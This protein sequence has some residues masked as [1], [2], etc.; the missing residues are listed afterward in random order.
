MLQKLGFGRT[1]TVWLC[2]E[3]ATGKWFAIKVH[4]AKTSDKDS[5]EVMATRVLLGPGGQDHAGATHVVTPLE[6]F[7]TNSPNG[8]HLCLVMPVLGPNLMDWRRHHV[9]RNDD[10]ARRLCRQVAEGMDYMHSKGLCH[11]DFRPGS[12]FMKLRPGCLDGMTRADMWKEFREAPYAE[13]VGMDGRK[14][15]HAPEWVV[16]PI[17]AW[18]FAQYATDDIA[19]INFGEAY[20]PSTLEPPKALKIPATLHIPLAYAAPEAAFE[21]PER[22]FGK[23]TD[24]WAL[25]CTLLE[26]RRGE[27]LGGGVEDVV[28]NM[29][30]L[31]GEAV[32]FPYRPAAER[33]LAEAKA[34]RDGDE[35]L[36]LKPLVTPL[37]QILG[38]V[39]NKE[40]SKA[41]FT[42]PI[43]TLIG[44]Y[45][46]NSEGKIAGTRLKP[47]NHNLPDKE[48]IAFVNLLRLVFKYNEKERISTHEVVEHPWITGK[49]AEEVPTTKEEDDNLSGIPVFVWI[50]IVLLAME[51]SL[52]PFVNPDLLAVFAGS[53]HHQPAPAVPCSSIFF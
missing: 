38:H 52:I 48:F 47:L 11:G 30:W 53:T 22:R 42:D 39:R 20:A 44:R 46:M 3:T 29:E 6:T 32:P 2:L 36:S 34:Q 14:S 7:H 13:V 26:V 45:M 51:L 31:I 18:R 9:L 21:A 35:G 19:I 8:R 49:Y 25:A 28:R 27:W 15:Q 16:A 33:M 43:E 50:L 41:T 5:R 24:V 23:G 1:A 10:R 40:A 12:I 17:S 37:D 4:S